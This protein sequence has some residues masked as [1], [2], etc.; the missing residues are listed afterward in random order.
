M[1]VCLHSAACIHFVV[2]F[3]ISSKSATSSNEQY[4]Q[5]QNN[6]S[7][8]VSN[9]CTDTILQWGPEVK[10]MPVIIFCVVTGEEMGFIQ[11][12]FYYLFQL[13][14]ITSL[15]IFSGVL[16]ANNRIWCGC[17]SD[18]IAD[19]FCASSE[20]SSKNGKGE[21]STTAKKKTKNRNSL[22]EEEVR[23]FLYLM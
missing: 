18:C 1:Q 8:T 6:I 22:S 10:W 21:S 17:I 14:K 3:S 15:L 16:N 4:Y 12:L 13:H 2:N 20:V 11:V 5:T 7:L 23:L 19:E 9:C